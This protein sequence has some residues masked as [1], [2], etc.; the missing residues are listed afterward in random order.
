[1][2]YEYVPLPIKHRHQS[3]LKLLI[4]LLVSKEIFQ[5]LS[6]VNITDIY[7]LISVI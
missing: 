4:N 1:M 3:I 6:D 5:I 7:Y 2:F